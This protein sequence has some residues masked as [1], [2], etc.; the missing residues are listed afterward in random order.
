MDVVSHPDMSDESAI[1][2]HVL[3]SHD[4]ET[5]DR[6]VDS[7][8][9]D[10]LLDNK[11]SSNGSMAKNNVDIDECFLQSP[12]QSTEGQ[13]SQPET[14]EEIHDRPAFRSNVASSPPPL[15]GNHSMT[16]NEEVTV[17]SEEV[18]YYDEITVDE[19][20]SLS[21][22]EPAVSVDEKSLSTMSS[23]PGEERQ[24]HSENNPS[25]DVIIID[26]DI[27]ITTDNPD[28]DVASPNAPTTLPSSVWNDP[29]V[30][31]RHSISSDVLM[32]RFAKA[33]DKK[34]VYL[35]DGTTLHDPKDGESGHINEGLQE[36][37]SIDNQECATEEVSLY[38]MANPKTS[39]E[40]EHIN[41][42]NDFENDI[43]IT[44]K[45][46]V[47]TEQP[48][49]DVCIDSEQKH[50]YH[51]ELHQEEEIAECFTEPTIHETASIDGQ[52]P[53]KEPQEYSEVT[54]NE[55][56]MDI[57]E[58]VMDTII[59]VVQT[60]GHDEDRETS[61]V[62]MGVA[63]LVDI[64][65][66]HEV[67][68]KTQD[69]YEEEDVE[70]VESQG[71]FGLSASALNASGLY[72]QADQGK[73]EDSIRL[74]D[75]SF[76]RIM[77]SDKTVSS[78]STALVLHQRIN[79]EN[80]G[81]IYYMSDEIRAILQANEEIVEE[82]S[83]RPLVLQQPFRSRPLTSYNRFTRFFAKE[84]PKS[85]Q[86]LQVP[87]ELNLMY[88]HLGR[89]EQ[90]ESSESEI[91]AEEMARILKNSV[92]LGGGGIRSPE[93]TL[94]SQITDVESRRAPTTNATDTNTD[95]SEQGD[96]HI[97]ES[98]GMRL[99][100]CLE[101]FGYY[102]DQQ[103]DANVAA[104]N[105]NLL[106]FDIVGLDPRAGS[107]IYQ[108]VPW[109]YDPEAEGEIIIHRQ[110]VS[111]VPDSLLEGFTDEKGKIRSRFITQ[112]RMET[113]SSNIQSVTASL[114]TDPDKEMPSP[115]QG[116][117]L[118]L[119]YGNEERE[120]SLSNSLIAESLGM[121]GVE[122]DI[123]K[124]SKIA[125]QVRKAVT[126][127]E[128]AHVQSDDP[129]LSGPLKIKEEAVSTCR[130]WHRKK[131]FQTLSRCCEVFH[132]APFWTKTTIYA[133]I[134]ML[135]IAFGM[136]ITA[137]SVKS[138]KTTENP[139]E[140][141]YPRTL[142]PTK[143]P[144]MAPSELIFTPPEV[145]IEDGLDLGTDPTPPEDLRASEPPIQSN[146]ETT[147]PPPIPPPTPPPTPASS[148]SPSVSPNDPLVSTTQRPPIILWGRGN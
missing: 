135:C 25:E 84:E 118:L 10:G 69:T 48:M 39:V 104:Q 4:D 75:G 81:S 100:A 142:S 109:T 29:I 93:G 138:N 41:C 98:S 121:G 77:A 88:G 11:S 61:N 122:D 74:S 132:D 71:K 101:A 102:L 21:E 54:T 63:G 3:S 126:W 13:F 37:E 22:I 146:E 87:N 47:Q 45:K 26:D 120:G 94:V 57:I 144:T 148:Q 119:P 112:L 34:A 52:E 7:I 5:V 64:E 46:V 85:N 20:S 31:N 141:L 136:M 50:S 89:D 72:I 82:T 2:S 78:L 6:T 36:E 53:N 116:T 106:K 23:D 145:V 32:Y 35:T 131:A 30:P 80:S 123:S 1:Y 68:D 14:V 97:V 28:A 134:F 108:Y 129:Q 99:K 58:D 16:S 105:D 147:D 42:F 128:F 139:F 103:N 17:F 55:T 12:L 90:E 43:D 113:E 40:D 117:S 96:V 124:S 91:S 44:M 70:M 27:L 140:G 15:H 8:M 56:T 92:L 137:L 111:R 24:T 107:G 76:T 83:S 86:V 38:D 51:F 59:G 130:Q 49:I 143:A 127:N 115:L 33:D 73:D 19:E 9:H 95:L 110:D 66:L 62:E 65:D 114:Y 67:V 79:T 18:S 60:K 133:S 125:G